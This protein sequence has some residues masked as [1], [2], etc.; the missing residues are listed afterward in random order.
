MQSLY[1]NAT[2]ILKNWNS[3]A[4]VYLEK[5]ENFKCLHTGND[6]DLSGKINLKSHSKVSISE[7]SYQVLISLLLV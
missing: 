6:I 4:T 7:I 5:T 2:E 3:S 1:S